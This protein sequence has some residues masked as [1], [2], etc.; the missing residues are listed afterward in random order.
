M[1]PDWLQRGPYIGLTR[2][3]LQC[4]SRFELQY[5]SLCKLNIAAKVVRIQV[6]FG[7]LQAMGGNIFDSVP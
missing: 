7:F 5:W 2:Y 4:C 3:G 1:F 6:R